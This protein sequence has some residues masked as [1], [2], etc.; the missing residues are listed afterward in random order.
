MGENIVDKD[1]LIDNAVYDILRSTQPFAYSSVTEDWLTIIIQL[2]NQA[3][4]ERQ[5]QLLLPNPATEASCLANEIE[6][7]L[8]VEGC[9]SIIQLLNTSLSETTRIIT[10][11]FQ[12]IQAYEKAHASTVVEPGPHQAAAASS[13]KEDFL[14][15]Y[16]LESKISIEE[17]SLIR[18]LN[19][20][21]QASF[22]FGVSDKDYRVDAVMK[23]E[24][25]NNYLFAR[26]L[27]AGLGYGQF[28]S[29]KSKLTLFVLEGINSP[30]APVASAL[31]AYCK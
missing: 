26:S 18:Q 6:N 12:V 30:K 5:Q 17:T 28:F 20:K 11:F 31:Q 3:K 14:L 16:D 25:K 7:L 24:N 2:S 15:P 22:F 1:K 19:T 21:L 9:A 23:I 4:H 27:Q 13:S 8:Q 29:A 10:A